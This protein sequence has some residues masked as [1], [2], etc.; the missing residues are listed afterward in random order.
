MSDDTQT[1]QFNIAY[2]PTPYPL[3]MR[4]D[5]VEIGEVCDGI[6]LPFAEGDL[7]YMANKI[8][9]CIDLAH[10]MNL[11]VLADFWGYGN[12]F[13]CGGIPSLFTVRHPEH[14]C[15][16]NTG[17]SIPKSC[18][19]KPTVRAFMKDAIEEFIEKYKPDGVFWDEPHWT[20]G[21]Y[22]G[23]LAEGEWVCRCPDCMERFR[24]EYGN[25]MPVALTGEVEA[26]RTDTMLR[27]LNEICGYVKACGDHLVTS[28]CVM[29]SDGDAFREAAGKTEHL[30]VFGIDPYWRPDCDLS[31]KAFIDKH[32][33][34]AVRIA[35]RNGK[36]AESWV[37]AWQQTTGHELDA[38]RAAK[39]MA[40][41][42]IDCLSAWSYRDHISW[43]PCD[44]PN[45]ADPE[46]VWKHLRR[47]YHEIRNGD[48]ELH[49]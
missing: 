11:I 23:E 26:F 45:P 27:F 19:N 24:Q 6:Y 3:A 21:G 47:A 46:R 14:N 4:Q 20:L 39:W 13:A 2:H 42:D 7:A 41:H 38:Y 28:T 31:Q 33:S 37:C 48:L 40:A 49:L 30:D 44:K 1:I 9:H 15:V 18:P 36:L 16:A 5:L 29:T 32:T 8:K 35:S 25:E 22:L 12:L 34:D 43:T 10:E 17:R